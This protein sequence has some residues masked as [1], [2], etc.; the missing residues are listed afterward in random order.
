MSNPSFAQSAVSP[1]LRGNRNPNMLV[2]GTTNYILVGESFLARDTIEDIFCP[3]FFSYPYP[4][5]SIPRSQ[6]S[7][8]AGYCHPV[9]HLGITKTWKGLS[10]GQAEELIFWENLFRKVLTD[11]VRNQLDFLRQETATFA[12]DGFGGLSGP[13][14]DDARYIPISIFDIVLAMVDRF[15][16]APRCYRWFA[17]TGNI[18]NV[19]AQFVRT[20]DCFSGDYQDS[21]I[22]D[23]ADNLRIGV[24][25]GEADLKLS[26]TLSQPGDVVAQVVW[27][28][29][30]LCFE[31]FDLT[32]KEGGDFSLTPTYNPPFITPNTLSQLSHRESILFT[33][34]ERWLHWDPQTQSFSGTVPYLSEIQ[35]QI[36]QGEESRIAHSQHREIAYTLRIT[37]R[38][39][40]AEDLDSR[41]RFEQSI[42]TRITVNITRSWTFD[43][44]PKL[45]NDL[46]SPEKV[47]P[48]MVRGGPFF[49]PKMDM[50]G[51]L[52]G[53]GGGVY[54]KLQP[55][56]GNPNLFDAQCFYCVYPER[57]SGNT[58]DQNPLAPQVPP[59]EDSQR[60]HS[61]GSEDPR[62]LAPRTTAPLDYPSTSQ[63]SLTWDYRVLTPE[64]TMHKRRDGSVPPRYVWPR[65]SI[66][67]DQSHPAQGPGF[68][69]GGINH[70]L[71]LTPDGSRPGT[72][73]ANS[74]NGLAEELRSSR[75][76]GDVS[77][78]D[79][80]NSWKN[81]SSLREVEH[82]IQPNIHHGTD[83]LKRIAN[84]RR[85][86]SEES[87]Q[88]IFLEWMR[89]SL[90]YQGRK[91]HVQTDSGYGSASTKQSSHNTGEQASSE[92]PVGSGT[93]ASSEIDL[94][95][96]DS[97][98]DSFATAASKVEGKPTRQRQPTWANI[99]A[100]TTPQEDVKFGKAENMEKVKIVKRFS[101]P[102]TERRIKDA[103]DELIRVAKTLSLQEFREEKYNGPDNPRL[104]RPE[105]KAEFAQMLRRRSQQEQES[106][107]SDLEDIFF[108]SSSSS[109]GIDSDDD[110]DEDGSVDL[111]E[112]VHLHASGDE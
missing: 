97:N 67:P 44:P 61:S 27:N 80:L 8:G 12:H 98:V 79:P 59:H 20:H 66:A 9:D 14:D 53:G 4:M 105:K 23:R 89:Q 39:I 16:A 77:R 86:R 110:D 78:V 7:M 109:S 3:R 74:N 72:I 24:K 92:W 18:Y 1:V 84:E 37:V 43:S 29:G 52:G 19:V 57:P 111:D 42:R 5:R 22:W 104:I 13:R 64:G 75:A 41:V 30:Y 102:E 48:G 81:Y 55:D 68:G 60:S 38:A 31:E 62:K 32:P 35:Q 107:G 96:S 83:S 99:V 46:Y 73:R 103:S 58:V 56:L 90:G 94:V 25:F 91:G 47:D 65:Y 108:A 6:D 28:P 93:E 100:G 82:S 54:D 40:V 26:T 69:P 101:K 88:S 11:L 95:N 63:N 36:E 50:S 21:I 106:L 87:N 76:D 70:N 71:G 49:P 51:H 34:S 85:S 17:S 33:T 112:G 2:P 45:V 10:T 15:R